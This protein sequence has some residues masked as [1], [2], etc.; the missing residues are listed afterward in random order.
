M[1]RP[2][3]V[4]RKR[5]RRQIFFRLLLLLAVIIIAST[6]ALKSDFFTIE[7]L[8]ISGNMH[9]SS[10]EITNVSKINIGDN[11]LK[12]SKSSTEEDINSLSY[13]KNVEFKRKFPKTIN[14][15]VEERTPI[16]QIKS[17]SSYLII[18]MEGFILDILNDKF[19]NLPT[20]EGFY[21]D[22]INIGDNLLSNEKNQVFQD[23]LNDEDIINILHQI[24]KLEVNT[25]GEINIKLNNGIDV[26]FGPLD[27]VKYKLRYLQEILNDIENNQ[28]SVKMILMNKGENPIIVTE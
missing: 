18:D 22:T 21:I 14:I 23:F 16:L 12:L 17:L 28:L 11:I 4:E 20:F 2:T 25:E 3:R 7:H 15:L 26:A 1:K 24:F 6:Y 9:L 19:E 10:E 8:N 13:I 5:R 27:N